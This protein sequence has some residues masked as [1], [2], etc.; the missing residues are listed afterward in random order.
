M[1]ISLAL[2]TLDRVFRKRLNRQTRSG[3]GDAPRSSLALPHGGAD[4]PAAAPHHRRSAGLDITPGVLSQEQ[5]AAG[6]GF[7]HLQNHG[8][9]D[10]NRFTIVATA[11]EDR[12]LLAANSVRQPRQRYKGAHAESP[13]ALAPAAKMAA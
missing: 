6:R 3:V 1:Q 2:Y 5:V 9:S 7:L 13:R 8:C 4:A 10:L 11:P 12:P